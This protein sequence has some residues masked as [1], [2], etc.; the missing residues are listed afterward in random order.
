MALLGGVASAILASACCIGPIIFSVLGV[1]GA[2][3]AVK[4]EPFR[5]VLIGLTV[6][7]FVMAGYFT[8]RKSQETGCDN[9]AT[10]SNGGAKRRSSFV[11]LVA[12]IIAVIAVY[13]SQIESWFN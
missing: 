4:F 13:F 9:K 6:G 7:M 12:V 2:A 8:F 5:P 11:F 10:G 1:G 3:A